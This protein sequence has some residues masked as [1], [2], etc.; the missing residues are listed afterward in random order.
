MSG[1]YPYR[2]VPYRG[3]QMPISISNVIENRCS[4]GVA[5]RYD[6]DI[7][8]S[9]KELMPNS[10]IYVFI[11]PES[12][13]ESV[14]EEIA[15]F[16][17]TIMSERS[18]IDDLKYEQKSEAKEDWD[19]KTHL[20]FCYINK[21]TVAKNFFVLVYDVSNLNEQPIQYGKKFASLQ[22]YETNIEFIKKDIP[23]AI[24]KNFSRNISYPMHDGQLRV[25]HKPTMLNYWHVE[26]ELLPATLLE[27]DKI[28]NVRFKKNK[29]PENYS[30]KDLMV[31]FV[32]KT[33]LNQNF[34]VNENLY[35]EFPID[36]TIDS[37]IGD[38]TR[39]CNRI[40]T[41]VLF[42]CTP[43]IVK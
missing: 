21:V 25:V 5:R 36:Y 19:K 35:G 1:R 29:K 17:M 32:W 8:D 26:L 28:R 41:K 11:D 27:S 3:L 39:N 24:L 18:K 22:D 15:G 9:L 2:L 42:E 12:V 30:D 37:N 33:Y 20:P 43:A 38:I 4:F 31:R 14:Y 23:D 34:S 16:S 40:A 7:K 13:M 6:G 10:G